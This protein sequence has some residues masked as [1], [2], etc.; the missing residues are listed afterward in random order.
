MHISNAKLFTH[1]EV[2]AL[3]KKSIPAHTRVDLY[4]AQR[5]VF[6]DEVISSLKRNG[7]FY[8]DNS[9]V[10]ASAKECVLRVLITIIC[11]HYPSDQKC[12][13]KAAESSIIADSCSCSEL[14]NNLDKMVQVYSELSVE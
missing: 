4:C 11:N 9:F 1:E 10:F 2:Y 7:Q 3:L 13:C 12:W 5:T 8:S 14:T 6:L